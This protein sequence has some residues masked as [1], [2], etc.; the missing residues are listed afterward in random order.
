MAFTAT[1]T[2]LGRSACMTK[3]LYTTDAGGTGTDTMTNANF[4]AAVSGA[5]FPAPAF[6]QALQA[7]YASQAAARTALTQ[8]PAFSFTITPQAGS[9]TWI[10]DVGVDGSGLPTLI[11]TAAAGV[12]A[13]ISTIVLGIEFR[14]TETR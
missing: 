4:V 9:S 6:L 13:A 2:Q 8:N 7:T 11:V 10:V 3:L 14:H 1:G 5:T 12:V